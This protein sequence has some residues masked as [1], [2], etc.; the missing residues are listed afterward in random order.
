MRIKYLAKLFVRE[1]NCT[2]ENKDQ[3]F[4]QTLE[5]ETIKKFDDVF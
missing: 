3:T 2:R 1:I 4:Y 5:T